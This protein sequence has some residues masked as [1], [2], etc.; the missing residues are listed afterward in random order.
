MFVSVVIPIFNEEENIA[1]LCKEIKLALESLGR[2]YE[3]IL[4]DDG[5]EDGSLKVLKELA[6]KDRLLRVISFF[7][8]FGQTAALVSGMNNASGE[9]IVFLDGDLQNDPQDIPLLV[10][11]IEEGYDVVSGWRKQRKDSF[12]SRCL[13]SFLANKLISLISGVH[14]HDYGCTLKAYKADILKNIKLYG[15]MHRFIPIYAFWLGA[16]IVEVPVNHRPRIYGKTKYNIGRVFKVILDLLTIK[17]LAHYRTK[18]IYVFGGSGLVAIGLS[19]ICVITLIYN[20][21]FHGVSMIQSPFLILS[22][23]LVIV[24][25]QSILMGFLAEMQIRTYFE[26]LGK[27]IYHIKEKINL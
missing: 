26:S 17:F 16:K 11:K 5:S 1:Q 22:A 24:G 23:L 21:L 13:P 19:F 15:E 2:D 7:R 27:P 14:L 9:I 3:I 20:K 12:L 8:N 18:P 4:V 25:V 6:S 10:K